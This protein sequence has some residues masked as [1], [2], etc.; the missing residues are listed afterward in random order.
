MREYPVY[1]L[2]V[3]D[4]VQRRWIPCASVEPS[5]RPHYYFDVLYPEYERLVTSAKEGASPQQKPI[6]YRTTMDGQPVDVW[7]NGKVHP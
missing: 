5:D 6:G 3:Y 2:Q 4:H 1:G 7:T